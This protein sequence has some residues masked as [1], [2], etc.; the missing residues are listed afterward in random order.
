MCQQH[1]GP[2]WHQIAHVVL[3]AMRLTV[4]CT[5]KLRPHV[6]HIATAYAAT[7][8]AGMPNKGGLVVRMTVGST[9]FAFCSCHLHA[10][11]G[12]KHLRHRNW[13]ANKVLLKTMGG[14]RGG[15]FN[16][17][18]LDVAHAVDHL[19]WLGDLNYRIDLG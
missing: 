4:Y 8:L 10:F 17:R 1:L 2:R 9:T 5:E 18:E 15:A 3:R 11:E 7:G 19:I 16:E 14:R 12:E 13:M 6:H